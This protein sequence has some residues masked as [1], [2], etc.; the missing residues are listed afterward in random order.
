MRTITNSL[1]VTGMA[2][3]AAGQA[4]F[5]QTYTPPLGSHV[6]TVVSCANPIPL[7]LA[8][9]DDFRFKDNYSVRHFRWWGTV[10]NVAQLNRDYYIAIYE[11][12]GCRPGKILFQACVNAQTIPVAV[13]CTGKVVYRFTTSL[14]APIN[15]PAGHYWFRVAESDASS[16]QLG[17]VDFQWSAVRPVRGCEAGQHDLAAGWLSPLLDPC[18][19]LK[20]DLAFCLLG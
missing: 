18:D 9:A 8:A 20:E 7:P 6:S 12:G 10:S 3:A 1:V 14:A 4:Q 16:V 19:G 2:L 11:G 5:L 17:S 13:D 15:V